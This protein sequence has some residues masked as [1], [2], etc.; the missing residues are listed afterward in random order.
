MNDPLSALRIDRSG[1]SAAET[2]LVQKISADPT[3][4]VDL[5]ITDLAV[6][7]ETS[8]STVARFAQLLGFS[9]YREFRLELAK[10]LSRERASQERYGLEDGDIAMT[11][12]ASD[13]I[14]KVAFQEV[15]AIEQTAAG[16]DP[17]VV[18]MLAERIASARTTD[19][20][21]VGASALAAEDFR[22]KLARVGFSSH[23]S[24]DVHVAIVQAA[25]RAPEDVAIGISHAGATPEVVE[26]LALAREN[27]AFTV[28]L[29]NAP[30]SP[31]THHAD[32]VLLTQARESRFRIGAMSSRI[33][34]L[35]VVDILFSRIIQ[36]RH[37][38]VRPI[39]QRTRE[40]IA[41]HGSAS[42][43]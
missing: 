1:L 8:P 38:E 34:Q 42:S 13:V 29:T 28:A 7:C 23:F 32:V 36:N 12:S 6:L 20:Y 33:A 4:V 21:A 3:L 17:D 15:R 40:A 22:L 39:L 18:D 31:L 16:L 37:D 2:R 27:G 35:T 24:P 19:L 26:T 30:E 9:G 10:S 25:Q 41:R 5:T 11:D 14:S 43:K